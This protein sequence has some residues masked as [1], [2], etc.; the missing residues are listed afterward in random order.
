MDYMMAFDG[1]INN[2][3]SSLQSSP[4]YTLCLA[5]QTSQSGTHG[6]VPTYT[7]HNRQTFIDSVMK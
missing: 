6:L 2:L 1:P 5:V 4:L 3:M 7:K